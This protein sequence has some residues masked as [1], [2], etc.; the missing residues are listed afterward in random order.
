MR[1]P[2]D[3]I[4]ALFG[5]SCTGKTTLGRHLSEVLAVPFRSC[6]EA[7]KDRARMLGIPFQE[8]SYHEHRVGDNA[9]REWV[10]KNSPC[11]VE[12]RYLDRVLAQVRREVI[13]ILLEA[14]DDDRYR[15]EEAKG[16]SP[17]TAKSLQDQAKADLAFSDH[18]YSMG[19]RLTPSLVLNSS[20]LPVETCVQ[21]IKS[22]IE[23]FPAR[24]G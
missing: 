2:Q 10:G 9:T 16:R 13:L 7:V 23:G 4:V 22:L 19:E 20:D 3:M 14:S 1:V 18:M 5:S 6:G 11:V 17:M 15:R 21:R 12:G 8:L 24:P